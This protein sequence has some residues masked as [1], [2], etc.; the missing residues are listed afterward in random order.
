MHVTKMNVVFDTKSLTILTLKL[1]CIKQFQLRRE[2]YVMNSFI[3]ELH[4][5]ASRARGRNPIAK[6]IYPSQKIW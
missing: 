3:A 1:L 5:R 6:V 4:A 2:L